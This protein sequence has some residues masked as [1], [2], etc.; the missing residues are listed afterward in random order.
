M[1]PDA[2]DARLGRVDGYQVNSSA[3]NGIRPVKGLPDP[4]GGF[5]LA[6]PANNPTPMRLGG[7]YAGP[8][9]MASVITARNNNAR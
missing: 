1:G 5:C 8:L 4:R 6:L 7:R 2:T 3:N 9:R